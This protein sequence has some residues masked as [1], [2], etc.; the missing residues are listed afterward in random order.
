MAFDPPTTLDALLELPEDE[1]CEFKEAKNRFSGDELRKYACAMANCGGGCIVFGVTDKRPR[2]V[3]GTNAFPQPEKAC[4]GLI[5]VLHVNVGIRLF[6]QDGKC[7]V[8]FTIAS[9]PI[10]EPVKDSN[11]TYWWREGERLVP[12]P[13]AV[14]RKILDETAEDFSAQVCAKAT[15]ADLDPQ[16]I[17]DFREQWVRKSGNPRL[18]T[19]SAEQLLRDCGVMTEEGVTNAALILFGTADALARFIPQAEIV[20]EYRQGRTA[21]PADVSHRFRQGFFAT[22]TPL[23]ELINLRNTTQHYQ[24]G[25]FIWDIPTFNE[26]VIREAVLNAICHRDYLRPGSVFIRQYQDAMKI[27]SPGGFPPGITV[28]NVLERQSP[29]NRKIA[30]VFALCGLVERAG[31][32]MNKMFEQAVREAKP[33]PTFDGSDDFQVMLTLGG[34]VVN[35]SLLKIL[36]RIGEETLTSFATE[37]FLILSSLANDKKL[38]PSWQPRLHALMALGIVEQINRRHYV[39][40]QRIAAAIGKAGT[41][42]RNKGLDRNTNKALILQLLREQGEKGA[43]AADFRQLFPA[44]SRDQIYPLLNELRDSGLIALQGSG[45]GSI[46]VIAQPNA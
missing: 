42:T 1:H 11:G 33:L 22:L 37:D 35:P 4:R 10:G 15:L 28:E 13:N 14:L 18:R 39:L 30:E 25:L 38:H 6:K 40:S 23:L 21:G 3:V 44:L 16:S 17:E 8:V 19:L 20:F 41:R 7:I 27:E 36:E 9:R 29:R 32:G 31:Q 2:Q 43:S 34:M 46:W 12:M 45:K 24:D 26:S 5:D